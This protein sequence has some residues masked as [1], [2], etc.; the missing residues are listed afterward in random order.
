MLTMRNH[1]YPTVEWLPVPNDRSQTGSGFEPD[2]WRP[3]AERHSE[4]VRPAS[5]EAATQQPRIKQQTRG[6]T[7]DGLTIGLVFAVVL[8]GIVGLLLP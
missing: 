6:D 4:Y 2:W 8:Q 5:P 7:L 1:E 3:M